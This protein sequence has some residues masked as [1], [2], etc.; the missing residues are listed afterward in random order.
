MTKRF[1]SVLIVCY[2]V[3]PAFSAD[4]ETEKFNNWHHWRGPDYSGAAHN[5]NPP[6]T[7]SEDKN[8]K[9]KA[10]IPGNGSSTPIIWGNK[11]FITTAIQTDKS[12]E[13]AQVSG[14]RLNTI[15]LT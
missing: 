8:I 6:T 2:F 7:W 15:N 10:E 14:D 9:W 11:V 1:L 13:G 5:A 3:A 4:F 12:K